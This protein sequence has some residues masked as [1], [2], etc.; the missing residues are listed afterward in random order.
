MLTK[1]YQLKQQTTFKGIVDEGR[2]IEGV[3][4]SIFL[5]ETENKGYKVSLRSNEY[6]NVSDICLIF[7]GGGHIRA[8]G[9]YISGTPEQVKDKLVSQIKL[10]LK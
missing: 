10:Q 1:N 8:A 2:C 5:R 3:E 6:V 7:G 4:V 9:A